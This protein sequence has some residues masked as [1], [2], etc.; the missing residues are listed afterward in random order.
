MRVGIGLPQVVGPGGFDPARARAF[1]ARAE[2]LG[3][4]SLWVQE[5]VLG[6]DTLLSP[7]EALSFAAACTERIRLGC[8][9]LVLPLHHPVRLARAVASLDH[10]SGGRLDLGVVAG[11]P[12]RPYGAFGLSPEGAIA[13][14]NENLAVMQALW[15]DD[16]VDLDGRFVHL[17]GAS[18]GLKPVQSPHPPLWFGGNHPAALRRAVRLGQGFIGAGSQTTA[19]F[20]DQVR[21]VASERDARGVT[22][23][24]IAKRVYLLLDDDPERARARAGAALQRLYGGLPADRALAFAVSGPPAACVAGLRAV[25]DAGAEL[26]VVT[27]L[28]DEADQMERLAGEVLPRLAPS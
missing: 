8:A 26:V 12:N 1:L 3:F 25:L 15:R 6:P 9:V 13:R 17:E 23:F 14:F 24:Q 18:V 2:E 19:A 16:T 7:F 22:D 27:L 21:L 10:L 4:E 11:G 28:E 5:H 20:A